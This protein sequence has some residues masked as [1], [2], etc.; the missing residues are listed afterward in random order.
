MAGK[1]DLFLSPSLGVLLQQSSGGDEL[2]T[3]RIC[4]TLS[5]SSVS[6][7]LLVTCCRHPSDPLLNSV[8]GPLV[9]VSEGWSYIPCFQVSP[10]FMHSHYFLL[11]MLDRKVWHEDAYCA[12]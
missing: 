8:L 6:S 2:A 7:H 9:A 12:W 3:S 1:E 4:G 11:L 5:I 10:E